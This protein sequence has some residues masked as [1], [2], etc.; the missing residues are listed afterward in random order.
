MYSRGSLCMYNWTMDEQD[1]TSPCSVERVHLCIRWHRQSDDP[2]TKYTADDDI[3]QS[4]YQQARQLEADVTAC[5]HSPNAMEFECV[6]LPFLMTNK[7]KTYAAYEYPPI[8]YG[9]RSARSILIKGFAIKKRDRCRFVQRIGVELIEHL[10]GSSQTETQILDWFTTSVKTNYTHWP[11]NMEQ[12][13][14][15]F[16]TTRL[17]TTYKS[18]TVVAP[19][20]AELYEIETGCRPKT[21][22]RLRYV[23]AS[24]SD[25][26]KHYQCTVTLEMFL[27]KRMFLDTTYYLQ[28]QLLL[29]IRQILNL[30]QHNQLFRQI[31]RC[32]Q[33]TV[34]TSNNNQNGIRSIMSMLK[35]KPVA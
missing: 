22:S 3:L 10:L 4:I 13:S 19:W 34:Q 14:R 5:F 6:K 30:P 31:E 25:N 28:K 1:G 23:V 15:F 33:L 26:R 35:R 11:T 21:D 32:V 12:L 16:I 27:D 8:P 2:S 7:K 20:V 9:W 17:A 29:S 18:D 24:F